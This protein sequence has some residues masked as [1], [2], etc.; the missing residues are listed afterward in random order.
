M[1][2]P[3][4]C[5]WR[6]LAQWCLECAFVLWTWCWKSQGSRLVMGREKDNGKVL[7]VPVP[8]DSSCV[9]LLMVWFLSLLPGTQS[10]H[11]FTHQICRYV[12]KTNRIF[13]PRW[14]VGEGN[15]ESSMWYFYCL[16]V[17]SYWALQSM[18]REEGSLGC[19]RVQ[20]GLPWEYFQQ[21]LNAFSPLKNQSWFLFSVAG[22]KI[23]CTS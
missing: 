4:D 11:N 3:Q 9:Y 14:L 8:G 2:G 23:M 10:W 22:V 6:R 20:P 16:G 13:L 1:L 5:F 19:L 21:D 15:G 17:S 12:V 18:Q 7:S